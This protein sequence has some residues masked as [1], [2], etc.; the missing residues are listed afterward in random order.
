[1]ML[2][3]PWVKRIEL[4]TGECT[5]RP[6]D[7]AT[8]FVTSI[9]GAF[10]DSF[11]FDGQSWFHVTQSERRWAIHG[12]TATSGSAL[13]TFMEF[14]E[15]RHPEFES[16]L[17]TDASMLEV[18]ADWLEEQGDPYAASLKPALLK[19][20]GPAGRW[21]LE[22]LDRSG[23]LEFKLK[24]ALVREVVVRVDASQLLSTLHRLVHLRACV[25]LEKVAIDQRSINQNLDVA[26]WTMW[27]D[28]RWPRSL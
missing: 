8:P 5:S 20:R 4:Q 21:F 23:Q 2:A 3:A 7:P 6:L 12:T 17:A 13:Y 9:T 25:A 11:R 22:G 27:S 16:A 26:K 24:D 15:A 28:I 1:M 10:N 18:Y 14:P 19:E